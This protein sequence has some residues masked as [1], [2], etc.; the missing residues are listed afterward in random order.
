MFKIGRS[1]LYNTRRIVE[2][3]FNVSV[4]HSFKNLTV[5]QER[6]SE[7]EQ[8]L[9]SGILRCSRINQVMKRTSIEELNTFEDITMIANCQSY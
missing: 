4:P 2:L 8:S 5:R 6:R 7:R 1:K 9:W 3:Q